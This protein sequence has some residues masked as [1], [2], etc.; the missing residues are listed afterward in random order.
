[1][2]RRCC[3]RPASDEPDVTPAAADLNLMVQDVGLT[4]QAGRFSSGRLRAGAAGPWRQ[5]GS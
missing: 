5:A 4:A 2:A 3:D 1:M